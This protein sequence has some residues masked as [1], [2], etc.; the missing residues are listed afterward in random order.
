M[1][2]YIASTNPGKLRDFAA[3][4]SEHITLEPL[5]SLKDIPA[6]AE[7]ELTFE[8]NARIKAIFYSQHTSGQIVIA[9]DSGLE[10]DALNKAPGVRSARYADDHNFAGPPSATADER[11]NLYLQQTL[12]KISEQHPKARYRCVLAA[13]R[14]GKILSIGDGTVE[15]EI[16]LTPR[17]TQG[18]G[19]DPL[20]YLPDR[21][22]TMAEL[23]PQT[24]LAFSHRGRAFT[25]LLKALQLG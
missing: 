9:D 14:D 8:G 23:D 7:D 11:N 3:A 1:H 18:F 6:P 21:D 2:L 22:K 16:L 17:G 20:F 13:A 10:V 12:S 19:Y 25:A 15:G 4:T 5:P 24:K